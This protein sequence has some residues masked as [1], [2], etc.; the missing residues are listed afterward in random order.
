MFMEIKKLRED[1]FEV[2]L[3]IEDLKKFN[4]DFSEFMASKIE[5][6][7]F[8]SIILNNID[9]FSSFS[10]K[11]KKV[12]FETF[13]VDNSYFLI[14]F[15]IIG[16]LSKDG[17]FLSKVGKNIFISNSNSIIF[18][19]SSFD[20][21]CDFFNYLCKINKQKLLLII[22]YMKFF[23]YKN[24]YFLILNDSIF[25]SP[26]Y[27]YSFL[28]ISEFAEFFSC[29]DILSKKIEELGNNINILDNIKKRE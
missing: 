26:I 21:F 8:F 29:S 12:I 14:E 1:K 3:H 17:K 7:D 6:F 28:Q 18:K 13:F 23:K 25:S 15:Y 20:T 22:E 9:K 27:D 11:D 4:I 2:V 19:F 24:N 10:L 5:N 16:I